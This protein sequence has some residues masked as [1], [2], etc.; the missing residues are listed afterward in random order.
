[1]NGLES[2]L[3]ENYQITNAVAQELTGLSAATI[4]RYLQLFV[5]QG[6]LEKSGTTKNTLYSLIFKLQPCFHI[7]WKLIKIKEKDGTN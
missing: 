1:M 7:S 3:V 6:L 4:R 2:Y 5:N